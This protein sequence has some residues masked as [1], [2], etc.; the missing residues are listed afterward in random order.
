MALA[1]ARGELIEKKTATLQAGY[2]LAAFKTRVLQEPA[3]LA[4]RL[5]Q[6]GLLDEKCRLAVVEMIKDDLS[7]MLDE[8]AGL[9]EKI[10]EREWPDEAMANSN[11]SSTLSIDL[12][13]HVESDGDTNPSE[14]R[15]ERAK[16]RRQ[17][18]RKLRAQGRVKG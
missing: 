9:P 16:R 6:A 3:G 1:T 2:L 12:R 14:I 7:S 10:A 13:S 17:K 18:M 8:L 5:V 11:K 4:R 15:A